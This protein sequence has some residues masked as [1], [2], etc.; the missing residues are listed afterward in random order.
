MLTRA[1]MLSCVL[2]SLTAC[3]P[4]STD[5][6]SPELAVQTKTVVVLPPKQSACPALPG[7]FVTAGDLVDAV[8]VTYPKLYGD[9]AAKVAQMI[10]WRKQH[11]GG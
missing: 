5:H 11:G 6:P 10:A 1:L 7:T 9:C 4:F 3:G 2:L 8:K